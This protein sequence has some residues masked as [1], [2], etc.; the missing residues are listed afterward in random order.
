MI[1]KPIVSICIPTYGRV[2]ILKNTLDSIFT[3]WVENEKFE[4]CIS[5]NSPTDETEQMLKMYYSD[6]TNLVYNKSTC[7]G[8]LNSIEALKLGKGKFLKLHNN[9]T[10][11]REGC[12]L[13]FIDFVSEYDDEKTTLFFTFG[14]IN[15][16]SDYVSYD[17]FDIFM[18]SISY[19]STWSTSF[20]I[21]SKDFQN[22]CSKDFKFDKMFPHT[23]LLFAMDSN[24]KFMV[25]NINY[26]NN[27]D[28][29]Q[30]GGYNLPQIFGTRYIGMC[31]DLLLENKISEK[32]Y[33]SI[34]Q[35]ILTFIADW[36]LNVK[37]FAKKYTFSF[38][39]WESIVFDLYGKEG[40]SFVKKN[41]RKKMVKY[42]IKRLLNKY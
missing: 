38:D 29:G 35:G 9:Y 37:F 30:K 28:V 17:S 32:T 7:E 5:D 8:F 24:K 21:M 12:L 34:K 22:I 23:S 31:K 33:D 2:E 19:F 42:I 20:G 27:Q 15:Q 39:N 14:S 36:Y 40:I 6:K 25:N 41:Y 1:D 13:K 16:D 11:F 10:K 26:F 18:Y 4:V 3:Q